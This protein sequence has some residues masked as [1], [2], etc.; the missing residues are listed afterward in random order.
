M[1]PSDSRRSLL[2]RLGV[3]IVFVQ[4]LASIVVA[5]IAV[6]VIEEFNQ[7]RIEGVLSRYASQLEWLLQADPRGEDAILKQWHNNAPDVRLTLIDATGRVRWDSDS[8]PDA[9]ENHGDRP[10]VIDAIESGQ[11]AQTRFSET[12]GEHMTYVARRFDI[13]GAPSFIRVSM[14]SDLAQAQIV[15]II[16]SIL[17]VLCALLIVTL[18]AVAIVS[19]NVD[20][21]VRMLSAGA[22]R[23]AA[24]DFS[25][26]TE[27][28]LPGAFADLG[29]SLDRIAED[30]GE[31]I[32]Q[33]SVQQSEMQGILFAMG[34]GVI[35]MDLNGHVISVN[36]AAARILCLDEV[37]IR[38]K[39]LERLGVDDR[40]IDFAK[41]VTE[42]GGHG[43]SEMTL[44]SLQGRHV[45]IKAEP[46]HDEDDRQVG[47]LLVLDDVTRLRRLEAMR[48]DF[49]SN[50][51]HELRTPI[52]AI[53]GYAELLVDERDDMQRHKYLDVVSRNAMRLSAI[54]EDLLALSRIEDADGSE[55]PEREIILVHELL[56]DVVRTCCDEAAG[57]DV[58]LKVECDEPLTCHASW[59]LLEQAISNLVVN[60][61][62]YG[63]SNS[64]VRMRAWS[65]NASVNI[66][67]EDEGPGIDEDSRRR[68]FE[69][70]YRIDQG[71]SREVGGTGLGL[72]IVKH[73]VL[74]HGG[75][76][77]VDST[78]GEGSVF[79][80]SLPV[81]SEHNL[82]VQHIES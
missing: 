25:Y 34:T 44:D 22:Q 37:D 5:W 36:P 80:V 75:S 43:S 40:L 2:W 51:S 31:R 74:A 68:L 82:N 59:Q 13:E 50:V 38:G 71:R 57:R 20:R 4:I 78:P 61:I 7:S 32:R 28:D 69:R 53:Q 60:A 67:V 79:T 1:N 63:P 18:C 33:L 54:I 77:D 14:R 17:V 47:A 62:R 16:R 11:S 41:S 52:T 58:I 39:P 15:P 72:A 70:F 27:A 81:A 73:I 21:D 66:A 64:T 8:N 12:L 48:T 3:P 30:Q 26:R 56:D 49:A 10:E 46:I 6:S 42:A 9:M 76:V 45:V 23:I 55:L 24:G 65:Q 29:M 19:R 35:A